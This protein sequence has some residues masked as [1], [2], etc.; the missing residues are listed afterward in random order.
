MIDCGYITKSN[1]KEHNPNWQ[2][3]PDHPYR[4][5]ITRCS[6]SGK[7]SPI[8]NLISQQSD[9]VKIYLYSKDPGEANR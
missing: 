4:L 9:V 6:G 1:I 3:I 7:R 8:F 2:Q 5:L